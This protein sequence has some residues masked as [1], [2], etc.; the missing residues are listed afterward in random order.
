MAQALRSTLKKWELIKLKSSC[1]SKD[2]VNRTKHQPMNWE[3]IF[4]NNP[5]GRGL[6]SKIYKDLKKVNSRKPNNP[7]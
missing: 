3:K 2:T 7:N 1:K 4:T 5:S 6:I